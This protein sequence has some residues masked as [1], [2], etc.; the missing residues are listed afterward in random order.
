[1]TFAA[2]QDVTVWKGWLRKEQDCLP[3]SVDRERV[4]TN[5]RDAAMC[6]RLQGVLILSH[7]PSERARRTR[8]TPADE[9]DVALNV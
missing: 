1:M 3:D 4:W 9:V 8:H 2:G 7:N 6:I 5:E